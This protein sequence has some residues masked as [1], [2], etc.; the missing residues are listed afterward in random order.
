MKIAGL[1][2][3]L[4]RTKKLGHSFNQTVR[5]KIPKFPIYL[6]SEDGVV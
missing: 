4:R 5:N 1:G 3:A 2:E 6:R